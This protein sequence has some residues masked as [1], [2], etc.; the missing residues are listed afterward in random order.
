MLTCAACTVNYEDESSPAHSALP[1]DDLACQAGNHD[2][3][4]NGII[5]YTLECYSNGN[6][7]RYIDYQYDGVT[8]DKEYTYYESNGK[9]K[10]RIDYQYDGVTKDKEYT[11]YESNGNTK[12]YIDYRYDGVTK[13]REYTYYEDGNTKTYLDY[14]YDGVTKDKEYTYYEDGNTKTYIDYYSDGTK[15]SNHPICYQNDGSTE[16]SCTQDKHG[17]TSASITCIN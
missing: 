13:F 1:A 10:T 2:N 14:R 5:D 7:K 12:A 17:C 6:R 16:E 4:H 11:Y 15:H 9:L 8:K 3:D